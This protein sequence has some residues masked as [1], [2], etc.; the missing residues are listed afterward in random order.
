[1]NPRQGCRPYRTAVP[2]CRAAASP[3]P[4]HA[5]RP[6]HEG[7]RPAHQ[8]V[9]AEGHERAADE[10]VLQRRRLEDGV[11]RAAASRR[12]RR[13]CLRGRKSKIV[14]FRRLARTTSTRSPAS[15]SACRGEG[16]GVEARGVA[17]PAV[18]HPCSQGAERRTEKERPRHLERPVAPA[19]TGARLPEGVRRGRSARGREAGHERREEESRRGHRHDRHPPAIER[20]ELAA[21]HNAQHPAEGMPLEK[22]PIASA[23]RPGK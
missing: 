9:H 11:P 8:P 17:V 2:T 7:R 15:P 18:Q 14:S 3:P 21:E 23:R 1:M 12:A 4:A 6:R 19:S 20:L 5:M 10:Q 22:M 13:S 16:G